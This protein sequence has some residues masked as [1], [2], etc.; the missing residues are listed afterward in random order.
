MALRWR[1]EKEVIEGKGMVVVMD[2]N[3]AISLFHNTVVM[4]V[5]IIGIQ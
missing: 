2:L 5:I 3:F 1:I 4:S